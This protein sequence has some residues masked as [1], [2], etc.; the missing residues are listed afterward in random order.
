MASFDITLRSTTGFNVNMGGAA[1][2][3]TK[4]KA[5]GAF[6]QQPVKLKAAGSF[7]ERPVKV[8]AGGA[9]L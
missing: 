2:G 8:R 4:L 1:S 9:W 5:S 7:A 3:R 6:T